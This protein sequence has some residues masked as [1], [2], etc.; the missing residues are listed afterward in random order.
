VLNATT[1]KTLKLALILTSGYRVC[2]DKRLGPYALA[3]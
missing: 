2:N 1:R 3:A